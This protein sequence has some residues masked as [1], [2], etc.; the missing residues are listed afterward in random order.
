LIAGNVV[1]GWLLW[2]AVYWITEKAVVAILRNY[3]VYTHIDAY[4][5]FLLYGIVIELV[6]EPLLIGCIVAAI[7]KGREMVATMTLGFE[8][9]SSTFHA[10]CGLHS[11][12]P[13]AERVAW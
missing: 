13:P 8:M 9:C 6:I 10:V 1:G 12:T 5:F 11:Q 7:A 2:L 4:V 3:Q